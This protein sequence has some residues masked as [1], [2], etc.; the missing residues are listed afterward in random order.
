ME[1]VLFKMV[2]IHFIES[3]ALLGFG[4]SLI[5]FNKNRKKIVKEKNR[6]K[7]KDFNGWYI[8]ALFFI[9]LAFLNMNSVFMDW[10]KKDFVQYTDTYSRINHPY[11]M[12]FS[13]ELWTQ[14]S[15]EIFEFPNQLEK[16]TSFLNKSNNEL[17]GTPI[18][19]TYAKR[20]LIILKIEELNK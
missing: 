16:N 13:A 4:I 2:V 20:S 8:V 1:Q 9:S 12:L 3:F 10:I 19:I 15:K 11:K 7:S 14:N 17:K 5:I 18:K 6:K